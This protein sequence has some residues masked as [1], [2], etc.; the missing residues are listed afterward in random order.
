MTALDIAYIELYTSNEA[1]AADY[2]VSSLGF[3]V[4]AKSVARENNGKNSLLLRQG[5]VRMIVSTGPA[6]REFLDKHG[7]GIADIALACDNVRATRDAAVAAGATAVDAGPGAVL[8]FGDVR[9]TLLPAVAGPGAW[10]PAGWTWT[11]APRAATQPGVAV[12]PCGRIRRLDHVAVCVR[13]GTLPG[14]ARFY[15]DAFSLAWYS[16][17]Y[18]DFGAGAMDSVVVRSPSGGV[19]FTLVAPDPARSAG[20]IA[21]FLGRNDGPGVQHLAFGVDDI[22]GAVHEAAGRGARF[23]PTPDA[24]YDLL[25]ARLP[26]LGPEIERLRGAGVLA[27]RDEWGYLFQLF[28]RSPHGRDTL[29]YEFIQRRGAR[30]F[31]SANIRAL[32]E[33]VERAGRLAA[34]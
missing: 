21:G 9:H 7:D 15:A 26:G 32:Y 10:R 19:T 6:T 29:F 31:G 18:V 2:L 4:V 3:S 12:Q 30:G 1:F 33:A 11:A 27:D 24:Y 20:Q 5:A 25:L 28:T 23:L 22:V 34:G 13:A 17:E 16:S 14:Y 8:G